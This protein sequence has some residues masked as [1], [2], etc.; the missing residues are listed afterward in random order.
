MLNSTTTTQIK[1]ANKMRISAVIITKNE[2]LNIGRCLSSLMQV[3]DEIV[4]VDAFS[5]DET[6]RV[7]HTFPNVRFFSRT[8]LGYSA[9]KNFGNEKAT[10]GYILSIDAD[11]ALSD[12]LQAELLKLKPILRGPEAYEMPR[13]NHIGSSPVH[14]SGWYPDVKIRLFPKKTAHW[15]G[16]FV[17]ERLNFHGQI[18]RLKSDLL[19]FTFHSAE[20]FEAKM[21]HYAELDAAQNFSKGRHRFFVPT[22][23]KAELKFLSVYCLHLGFLD[24]KNGR[25]IAR[26]MAK[27]VI[28]KY[29]ALQ[30]LQHTED[31]WTK[32]SYQLANFF[33]P[34]PSPTGDL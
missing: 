13:L 30:K 25:I 5:Q 24:G 4:I 19:H 28:W 21:M 10:H 34:H 6:E 14:H 23:L 3:A 20:Q 33:T 27:N 9:A 16:D 2:A 7:C 31:I 8:W 15:V 29:I 26:Q 1:T 32:W 22:A 11:E 12:T 18:K 17:H